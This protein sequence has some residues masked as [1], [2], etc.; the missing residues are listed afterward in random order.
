VI[1]KEIK[2]TISASCRTQA[3]DASSSSQ[4]DRMT[5]TPCASSGKNDLS[6]LELLEVRRR[7]EMN[8]G[9]LVA[10]EARI[11]SPCLCARLCCRVSF[12]GT[13]MWEETHVRP[14]ALPLIRGER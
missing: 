7:T 14:A 11:G 13:A 2:Y 10:Q 9:D 5:T 4:S 8:H 1:I 3:S 6:D 12:P